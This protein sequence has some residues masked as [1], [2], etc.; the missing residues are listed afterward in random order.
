MGRCSARVTRSST[1]RFGITCVTRTAQTRLL[2]AIPSPSAATVVAA[3]TAAA[4]TIAVAVRIFLST[5]KGGSETQIHT[6]SGGNP[7]LRG[8]GPQGCAGE[9]LTVLNRAIHALHQYQ[10]PVV[11]KGIATNVPL[12]G[13]RRLRPWLRPWWLRSWIRPWSGGGRVR[14]RRI[15]WWVLLVRATRV[16]CSALGNCRLFSMACPRAGKSPTHHC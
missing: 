5:A 9:P 7:K 2:V 15:R 14:G 16:C 13:N 11:C 3:A 6:H 4:T 10:L 12:L 8:R 1:P